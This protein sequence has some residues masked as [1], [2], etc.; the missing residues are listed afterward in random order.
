MQ[1]FWK[2][3]LVFGKFPRQENFRAGLP[4]TKQLPVTL[5]FVISRLRGLSKQSTSGWLWR[6]MRDSDEV[7][8]LQLGRTIELFAQA[9]QVAS[10]PSFLGSGICSKTALVLA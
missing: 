3:A 6:L 7:S 9:E 4:M 1:P 8:V 5:L 2:I 10:G